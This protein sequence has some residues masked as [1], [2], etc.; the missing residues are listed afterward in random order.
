M[1]FVAL[2]TILML[3]APANI[4]AQ[5]MPGD[6]ECPI[7]GE[8]VTCTGDVSDGISSTSTAITDFNINNL[9][10]PITAD[11]N[12]ILIQNFGTE[13]VSV[14]IDD[15]VNITVIDNISDGDST[16]AGV[17]IFTGNLDLDVTSAATLNTST[18]D[19]SALGLSTSSQT[20]T[21]T[22]TNTGDITTSSGGI[23][24]IDLPTGAIIASITDGGVLMLTNSGTLNSDSGGG[25]TDTDLAGA[26][27]GIL[28]NNFG[29]ATL[30]TV[31]NTGAVNAVGSITNGINLVSMEMGLGQSIINLTNSGAITTDGAN[32]VGLLA[33]NITDATETVMGAGVQNIT[34]TC[35]LYTSPSPRD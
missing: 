11:G 31:I 25:L 2:S 22:V 4:F 27:A 5:T 34:N 29:E 35:L 9:T 10:S 21:H 18:T 14:D 13:D 30:T 12:G 20:G 23:G 6:P 7:S 16:P 8:S 3:L 17:S 33:S 19:F 15:S 26:A 28:T 32:T 1:K 24:E